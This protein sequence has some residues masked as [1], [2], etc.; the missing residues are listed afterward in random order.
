MKNI[1]KKFNNN[2]RTKPTTSLIMVFSATENEELSS[3]WK[4]YVSC[5]L[6]IFA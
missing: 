4:V 1:K 5:N 6:N 3:L 2:T